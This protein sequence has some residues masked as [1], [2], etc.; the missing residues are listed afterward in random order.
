M[1]VDIYG[2]EIAMTSFG[3]LG[4]VEKCCKKIGYVEIVNWILCMFLTNMRGCGKT[5]SVRYLE[6]L[7][8]SHPAVV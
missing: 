7:L 4:K 8:E 2:L 6:I 3:S 1:G 5:R